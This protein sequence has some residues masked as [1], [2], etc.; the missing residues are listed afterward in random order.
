M[1]FI[2][3]GDYLVSCSRDKTIRLWEVATGYCKRTYSGHEGWVRKVVASSDSRTLASC[4]DDQS[5]IL[6]NVEK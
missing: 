4:S 5:V 2:L 6:W 1:D 3:G